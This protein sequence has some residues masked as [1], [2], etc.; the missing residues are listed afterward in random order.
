MCN[1]HLESSIYK[2]APDAKRTNTLDLS[3][4]RE[5]SHNANVLQQK[6]TSVWLHSDQMKRFPELYFSTMQND[7]I[8][9]K[10]EAA[11]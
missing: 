2:V 8:F 5:A 9:L 11:I 1:D 3:F 7:N 4:P 6:Y 10:V